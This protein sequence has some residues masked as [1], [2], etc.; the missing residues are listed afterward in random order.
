MRKVIYQIGRLDRS[1]NNK[2]KFLV[3][4]EEI[5]TYLSSLA[6]K[7]YL[8]KNGESVKAKILFPVSLLINTDL[9]RAENIP[10]SLK[11]LAMNISQGKDISNLLNNY[12][13][14]RK[15]YSFHPH[16]NN[17]IVEF[18]IMHSIGQYEGIV[19][20]INFQ[21]IVLEIFLDM[22]KTY[23]SSKFEELYIDISSGQNIYV[24]ALLE[25][26]RYFVTFCKLSTFEPEDLKAFVI[27]SDPIVGNTVGK[28]YT[29]HSPYKME[30]KA[31]FSWP[32]ESNERFN[33]DF[34]SRL[35]KSLNIDT[36][37]KRELRDIFSG[38]LERGYLLFSAINNIVPLAAYSYEYDSQEK[39]NE[40]L[41]RFTDLLLNV[42]KK[43]YGPQCNEINFDAAWKFYVMLGI[44]KKLAVLMDKYQIKKTDEVNILD[45]E[46]KFNDIYEN[47]KLAQHKEILLGEIK[48]NFKNKWDKF[49]ENF[50]CLNFE[51]D[52][53]NVNNFDDRNFFAHCGFEM[54]ITLVRK[55]DNQVYVKYKPDALNQIKDT[56]LKKENTLKN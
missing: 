33:S 20:D 41:H 18:E 55:K 47:L 2:V 37:S 29:I 35:I 51:N 32:K 21:S 43:S 5:E 46:R 38:V 50:N 17:D 9:V 53:K 13:E 56:L 42:L 11:E 4:G 40:T 49:S 44:Y 45:L 26:C 14:L 34:V 30:V 3:D 10:D 24:A 6:Y 15:I 8:E 12:S 54:N 1:V 16:V 7:E 36:D 27:Y 22:M 28:T 39:I 48:K 19:F 31:F 23:L 25:A 52:K